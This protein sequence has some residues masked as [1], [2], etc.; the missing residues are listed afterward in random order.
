MPAAPRNGRHNICMTTAALAYG[1][2]VPAR[3]GW[4]HVVSAP[5][6]KTAAHTGAVTVWRTLVLTLL[7]LLT[8]AGSAWAE[9]RTRLLGTWPAGT[10]VELARGQAFYLHLAYDSDEPVELTVRPLW[11]GAPAEAGVSLARM[12]QGRGETLLSFFL[13][14]PTAQVDEVR[15]VLNEGRGR[16]A[17]QQ[18]VWQGLV[19]SSTGDDSTASPAKPAWLEQMLEQQEAERLQAQAQRRP[20]R[21]P[22]RQ[23]WMGMG[24]TLTLATALVSGLV[25]PA[26]GLWRWRGRWRLAALVPALAMVLVVLRMWLGPALGLPVRNQW[27]AELVLAGLLCTLAMALLW[28]LRQRL[29]AGTATD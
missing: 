14:R 18:V 23:T 17:P 22:A 28:L 11:R 5:G 29:G 4:H 12:H 9:T 19:H 26:W 1:N 8:V 7:M 20:P 27:Q 6:P 2:E 16:A 3:A 25:T 13:L 15:I 24:V 10:Q 21:Q